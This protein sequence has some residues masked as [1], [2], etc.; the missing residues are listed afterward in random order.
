MQRGI[1][2]SGQRRIEKPNQRKE[3]GK[4]EKESGR[5]VRASSETKGRELSLAIETQ[6]QT[7]HDPLDNKEAWEEDRGG[8]RVAPGGDIKTE[9][10]TMII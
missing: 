8:D 1:A 6:G 3:G 7:N 5:R 4:E 2:Q 9:V 10:P